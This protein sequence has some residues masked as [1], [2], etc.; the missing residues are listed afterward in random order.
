MSYLERIK[1]MIE[2][3]FVKYMLSKGNFVKIQ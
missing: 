2:D 1:S 3:D